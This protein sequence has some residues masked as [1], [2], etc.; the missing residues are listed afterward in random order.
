MFVHKK[1]RSLFSGQGCRRRATR[2]D[3]AIARFLR[4][5]TLE[6]RVT[7]AV[8]ATFTPGLGVLT[9]IGDALD[10]NVVVSRNAAGALLVNGGAVN[11]LAGQPT[12]ANTTQIQ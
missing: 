6:G 10:N 9:V 7:P 8:T 4:I 12:V 5:E 11:I 3:R 1:I 2:K